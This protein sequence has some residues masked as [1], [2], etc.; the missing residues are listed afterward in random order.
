M[1]GIASADE[2]ALFMQG[3][4]LKRCILQV[5]PPPHRYRQATCR[6]ANVSEEAGY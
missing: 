4:A 6:F 5:Q 2:F 3:T 1:I